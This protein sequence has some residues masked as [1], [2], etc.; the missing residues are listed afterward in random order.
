MVTNGT[1]QFLRLNAL[2]VYVILSFATELLLSFA[3][4]VN[5]FCQITAVGL[6]PFQ[7]VLV[8]PV[9][10]RFSLPAALLAASLVLSPAVRLYSAAGRKC[11]CGR[12]LKPLEAS[13]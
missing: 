8:G 9:A 5:A 4:I 1:R 12:G 6:S 2:Q 3:L 13:G 10:N 7:S 11:N